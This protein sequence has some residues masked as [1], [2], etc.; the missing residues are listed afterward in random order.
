MQRDRRHPVL[1]A[2]LVTRQ[3]TV[4]PI[5]PGEGERVDGDREQASRQPAELH[6]VPQGDAVSAKLV[7]Q[8]GQSGDRRADNP[9]HRRHLLRRRAALLR[10]HTSRT[11]ITQADVVERRVVVDQCYRT[12]R[13]R[14]ALAVARVVQ[15][16]AQTEVR[17]SANRSSVYRA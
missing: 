8:S 2:V 9:V 12:V 4:I 10:R 14:A 15:A 11:N 5:L 6:A 16:E 1:P 7:H 3:A 17:V 13:T